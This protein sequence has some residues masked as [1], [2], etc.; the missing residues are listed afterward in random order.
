[1]SKKYLNIILILIFVALASRFINI[2]SF[3]SET[4]DQ[5]PIAQLLKYDE[6]NLYDLANDQS[7]ATYESKSK[8]LLRNL[9]NKENRL[10]DFFQNTFSSVIFNMAP[11]KHSTF[12]PLQYFIFGWTIDKKLNY[13]QLKFYGRIPSVFFSFLT[14]FITFKICQR[15]IFKNDFS[16]LAT[17]LIIFSFPLIYISQR[18]YNYSAA[19]FAITFL[20][21]LFL[22]ESDDNSKKTFLDEKKFNFKLNFY[23][24][25]L[26]SLSSYLS[27]ITLVILPSFFIFKFIINI[28]GYKKFF[29]L[30]Y[31]NLIFTGFLLSVL[32]TPLL[33]HMLS[34]NLGDY[35]MTASTAGAN[36]EY[37]IKTIDQNILS[38]IAF[39]S[40]NF[41]LIISKNISFFLDNNFYSTILQIA[42]FVIFVFGLLFS[43]K[44]TNKNH[45]KFLLLFILI[46][47]NWVILVMLNITAFGPTRHLLIFAPIT[48]IFFVIGFER[49]LD[50][51][52]LIKYVNKILYSTIIL[53]T[54][55][56]TLNFISF[57]KLYKD[58]F[59]EDSLVDIIKRENVSLI[60]NGSSHADVLCLMPSIK[61]K[62]ASCPIRYSRYSNI[63]EFN[64]FDLK[65]IKENSQSIMIINYN[66]TSYLIEKLNEHSFNK[67]IEFKNHR[68]T[69]GSPLA[70]SKYVPNYIEYYIYK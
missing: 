35:G 21:Y 67:S 43:F 3:L 22:N 58:S 18:S 26:I 69:G 27:Y 64:D 7:S 42:L 49:L 15:F 10:I 65:T 12:A 4:D 9:E 2:S 59:D 20:L 68:Y 25:I 33:I 19:V 28:I 36:W 56:F 16:Y 24:S 6:L 44:S 29:C 17:F 61:V 46:L 70:I 47:V 50:K 37:S 55:I 32:V 54:I 63:Y 34:I 11:S 38:Y 39:F 57:S 30:K 41:Y 31:I 1:M 53:F 51:L 45:S 52:T 66:L 13:N 40:K 14:I 5:L 60:I 62:I 8:K 48:S 23:F